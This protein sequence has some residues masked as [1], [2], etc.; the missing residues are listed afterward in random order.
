MDSR[1]PALSRRAALAAGGRAAAAALLTACGPG[2]PP[3]G[4]G[5]GSSA[6][7]GTAGPVQVQLWFPLTGPQADHQAKV[8]EAFTGQHPDIRI[9]QLIVPDAELAVKLATAVAGG[10][11]PEL[12]TIG[13][14]TR[15][16]ELIANQKVVSLTRYRKDVARLDWH[17]AFKRVLVR[18]DDLYA[19]PLQAGT[20][21]LFYNADLYERAG[22]DPN[23][24]PRTWEAL[25]ANAQAIARPAAQLWGHYVATKATTWTAEQVW[26]ASLWQ[27]GGEWL[28]GDGKR[29]AFNSDAGIEALQ[30]WT[31]LVQRHRVAPQKA[32]D[33]LV[34]GQDFEAGATGQITH[35]SA[36]A[37]RAEGMRFPVRTATLPAHRRA[38]TVAGTASIPIFAASR[39]RDAAWAYLDWLSQPENL[40]FYLSG[41]GST[42]PRASVAGSAA[43]R[44][45]ADQ[46]PLLQAFADGQ[47][48]AR[49]PYFGKGAQEIALRVANAIEA[50]VYKQQTPR[51]AL[52]AA[53]RD[54]DAILTR[55]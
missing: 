11:P 39:Q 35:Y 38:A 28:S 5:Q 54:A 4:V 41:F 17:D 33:N 19:M 31:D 42:P 7:T 52:D 55:A 16:A 43:W 18:G 30:F 46:H 25:L 9:E 21:A 26:A 50:A 1:A 24:P 37:I 3:G 14:A 12:A 10:V 36:W 45:F 2:I 49:L 44:A 13:G 34:M 27:A 6:P 22:L 47:A 8:N 29:A 20:L 53:A 40:I 48:Q 23:A 32:V 15:I 51:Q